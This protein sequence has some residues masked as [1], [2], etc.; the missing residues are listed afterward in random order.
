PAAPRPVGAHPQDIV[1][2]NETLSDPE[3]RRRVITANDLPTGLGDM[4]ASLYLLCKAIRE[5]STVALSGESADEL[6]GGY[7]Q[8]HDPAIQRAHEFP[9]LAMEES[10]GMKPDAILAPGIARTLDL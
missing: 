8:F 10:L 3:L 9:W 4:Y 2:D 7:Q 1:L 6:F 5:H